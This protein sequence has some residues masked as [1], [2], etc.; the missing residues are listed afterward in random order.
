MPSMRW[1]GPAAPRHRHRAVAAGLVLLAAVACAPSTAP[2]PPPAAAAPPPSAAPPPPA[3]ALE[4]GAL[5][6]AGTSP[7]PTSLPLLVAQEAGYFLQHGLQVDLS[8]VTSTVGVQGLASGSVDVYHGGSATI[9]AT[10]GGADLLYIA[11]SV[12]RSSLMLFGER[13]IARVE[14]F[15]GKTVATTAAGAFG[16]I[17][18]NHT[19]R[20]HGLVA[21]QDVTLRYNPNSEAAYAAFSTGQTHGAIVLPPYNIRLLDQG[22]PL[23]VDY[24]QQGLKII[25]PAPGVARSFLRANPNTLKAFLMGYLDGVKRAYEDPDYATALYARVNRLEDVQQAAADYDE[26]RRVW[27]KDLTVDPAAIAIV[28]QSSPHPNASTANPE[29]F[30]DNSLI[31]EINVTYAPRLFPEVF[32]QR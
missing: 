8:W 21:G 7:T 3:L 14:D 9:T 6:V 17:A 13:G 11:A 30:Y 19:L 22:Y 10:L 12:D 31:R 4:R 16:E 32:G 25:G 29:D 5:N 20:E 15:R 26:G 1:Q 2:T 18:F 24:Y 23:I 27:N 28:L